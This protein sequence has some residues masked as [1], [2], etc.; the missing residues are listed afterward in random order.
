M[1]HDQITGEIVRAAIKVHTALG[2]GLL[3]SAYRKCLYHELVNRGLK[4]EM[5]VAVPI[6]YEGRKIDAGYRIDLIV[7]H[8]VL[9]ETKT[10]TRFAPVHGAQLLTHLRLGNYPVGLLINFHVTR[11]RNGIRRIV[12]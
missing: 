7:E 9:V 2:P 3:E 5:E 8:L 6:I 1:K 11:L 12:N 4:V 10:V